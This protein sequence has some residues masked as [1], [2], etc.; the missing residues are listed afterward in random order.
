MKTTD[1]HPD[2]VLKSFLD[3][4]PRSQKAG[5]LKALHDICSKQHAAQCYAVRDFSLSTIG[6][7]CEQAGIFKARVLYNAASD[8]YVSLI[9]AWAAYSGSASTK[10]PKREL[11]YPSTYPYLMR[12]E[13]PAIRSIMQSIIAERDK[14]RSQVAL[15]KSQTKIV[16]DQRPLGATIAP[17][18]QNVATVEVSARLTDSERLALEKAISTAFLLDQAWK[19][20]TDGEILNDA[21]RVLYDPGYESGIRKILQG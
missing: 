13:D 3:K 14:L 21:G 15:L 6:R 5:N 19:A 2:E 7:L 4:G 10:A 20:G 8:D 16:V 17:S 9:N 1:I 18:N 12:I 11:T